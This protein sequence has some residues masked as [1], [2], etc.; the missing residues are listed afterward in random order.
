[1]PTNSWS[2]F[3]SWG[4]FWKISLFV[5]NLK[6]HSISITFY[7]MKN[8]QRI[9]D[10]HN[11]ELKYSWDNLKIFFFKQIMTYTVLWINNDKKMNHSLLSVS[12]KLLTNFESFIPDMYK[13]WLIE[14]LFHRSFRLCSNYENFQLT[15]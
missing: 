2:F 13:R 15:F 5:W 14:T 4:V 9:L 12:T 6:E 8:I 1:M 7:L 3:V 10:M 11:H